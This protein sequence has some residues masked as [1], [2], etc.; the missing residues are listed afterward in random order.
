MRHETP[1]LR[2]ARQKRENST[3]DRVSRNRNRKPTMKALPDRA[4]PG[5]V[6]IPSNNGSSSIDSAYWHSHWDGNVDP[7]RD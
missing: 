4:T 1:C 3:Q 6:E 2:R 7:F 5:T